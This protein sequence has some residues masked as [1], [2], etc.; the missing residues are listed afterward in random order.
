MLKKDGWAI[1]QR[2][3]HGYQ[4]STPMQPLAPGPVQSQFPAP[5]QLVKIYKSGI[6]GLSSAAGQFERD[7]ER[8]LRT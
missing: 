8:V 1:Q 3:T 2:P 5:T 4:H 7:W 6:W